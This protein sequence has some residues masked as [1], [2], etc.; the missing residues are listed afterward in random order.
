MT[1]SFENEP[2]LERLLIELETKKLNLTSIH[3]DILKLTW[4]SS[5]EKSKEIHDT[6]DNQ[7]KIS[8][9]RIRA[10][11]SSCDQ[12]IKCT[13]VLK[14]KTKAFIVEKLSERLEKENTFE[15]AKKWEIKEQFVEKGLKRRFHLSELLVE[16]NGECETGTLVDDLRLFLDRYEI[17]LSESLFDFLLKKIN[18]YFGDI[19]SD[20]YLAKRSIIANQLVRILVKIVSQ[21]KVDDYYD[22]I[23]KIQILK[24]NFERE[25]GR[26]NL[27]TIFL[28]R[29]FQISPQVSLLQFPY[30][31]MVLFCF[32]GIVL[33][34]QLLEH[35]NQL[36]SFRKFYT[37]LQFDGQGGF[38]TVVD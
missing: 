36:Q 30:R 7:K 25:K 37:F 14:N 17:E 18:R 12:I 29:L 2:I 21:K 9:D 15:F 24:S 28:E 26:R 32:F 1:S 31:N 6:L 35:R 10:L 4:S 22:D 8:L 34:L 38:M 23:R 3:M 20:N 16:K 5:K 11:K 33:L 27:E 13:K 19:N